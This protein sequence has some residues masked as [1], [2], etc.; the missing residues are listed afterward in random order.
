MNIHPVI[1][2]F[3]VALLTVYSLMELLR[4]K[5]ISGQPYWFYA[6]AIF[7]FVGGLGSLAALQTG[8][9]AADALGGAA[10]MSEVLQRHEFF[11]KSSIIIFGIL[12]ACYLVLWVERERWTPWTKI[13]LL[14][15]IW[16]IKVSLA[17]FVVETKLVILLALAGLVCITITGGLGGIMVYGT[18]ADPFF[19]FIY[20]LMFP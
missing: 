17:K 2:H 7:L 6:K 19:G 5:K 16:L 9:W 3:P 1:V 15:R 13:E 14:R 11:A 10:R 18:Q 8:E 20:K 12:A 4:F